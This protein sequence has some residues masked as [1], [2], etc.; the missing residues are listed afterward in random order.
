MD[1]FAFITSLQGTWELHNNCNASF[2]WSSSKD[3]N[4]LFFQR[5]ENHRLIQIFAKIFL[6]VGLLPWA[7]HTHTHIYKPVLDTNSF[8]RNN[9]DPG[10]TS[11]STPLASASHSTATTRWVG[12]SP[13]L[14]PLQPLAFP[15]EPSSYRLVAQRLS[16][17]KKR[18]SLNKRG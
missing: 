10:G 14:R 7:T 5:L 16:Q 8:W 9:R 6:C 15:A 17:Q 1:E 2:R 12:G 3:A 18:V 4:F 11:V 13:Y